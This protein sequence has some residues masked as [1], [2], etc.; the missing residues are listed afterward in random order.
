MSSAFTTA[1]R[2]A[3]GS[4]S[5]AR[6]T[7]LRCARSTLCVLLRLNVNQHHV[8]GSPCP[9]EALPD[10]GKAPTWHAR[11]ASAQLRER[12]GGAA[13]PRKGPFVI[14]VEVDLAQRRLEGGEH[15]HD[16]GVELR[17]RP[18]LDLL[19]GRAPHP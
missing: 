14:S 11:F 19:D 16:V 17:A 1:S 13:G 7:Q 9:S 15:E 12:Q 5:R 6:Q 4:Q 8:K 18:A 3:G 2:S 10:D